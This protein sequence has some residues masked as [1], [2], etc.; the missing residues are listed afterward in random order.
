[1]FGVGAGEVLVILLVALLVV[2]PERLPEVSHR[3]GRALRELRRV[4]G[5][6]QEQFRSALDLDDLNPLSGLTTSP[7]PSTKAAGAATVEHAPPVDPGPPATPAGGMGGGADKAGPDAG[8]IIAE[9][10]AEGRA[11][12]SDALAP[13]VDLGPPADSP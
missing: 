6:A 10:A 12:H 9:P 13:P 1:M 3:I 11:P 8:T 4:Q 5:E 2:G 7:S